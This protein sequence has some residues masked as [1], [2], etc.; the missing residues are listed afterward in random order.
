MEHKK[1]YYVVKVVNNSENQSNDLSNLWILNYDANLIRLTDTVED[2]KAFKEVEEAYNLLCASK[3]TMLKYHELLKKEYIIQKF[4]KEI[5]SSKGE[6][7]ILNKTKSLMKKG[8]KEKV[9]L[10]DIKIYLPKIDFTIIEKN[11]KND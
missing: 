9:T 11:L 7:F 5:D 2:A 8:F 4:K 1:E 6:V 3:E 10:T